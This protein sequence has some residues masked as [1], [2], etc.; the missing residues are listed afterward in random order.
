VHWGGEGGWRGEPITSVQSVSLSGGLDLDVSSRK[1][2]ERNTVFVERTWT[3]DLRTGASL[4]VVTH[5]PMT[6]SFTVDRGGEALIGRRCRSSAG[7]CR[8]PDRRDLY[9][10][11]RT[12]AAIV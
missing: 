3:L 5:L 8:P 11:T 2:E 1:K 9:T 7:R 12:K 10:S 4:V 6:K